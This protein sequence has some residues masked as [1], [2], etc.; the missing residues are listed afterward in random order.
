[1]EIHELVLE[2]KQLERRLMLYEEKYGIL[3]QDFYDALK[4]GKAGTLR[5]VR[6][7]PNP[8]QPLERHLRNLATPQK[9]LQRATPTRRP[10]RCTTCATCLLIWLR[11]P[12]KP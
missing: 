3:S 11:N 5:R 4:A 8:F 7:N 10:S 6:R 9:S 1:M 12:S 2:M